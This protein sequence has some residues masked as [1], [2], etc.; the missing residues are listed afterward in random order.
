MR[1]FIT[2][3]GGF[4]GAWISQRL[5]AARDDDRGLDDQACTERGVAR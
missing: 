3:G 5:L 2:D 1:D 4:I